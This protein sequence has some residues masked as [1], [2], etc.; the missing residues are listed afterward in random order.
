MTN[1]RKVW[2]TGLRF[3]EA[4]R[5][6]DGAIWLSDLMTEVVWRI[7][8]DTAHATRIA[9]IKDMPCGLGFLPDGQPLVISM[10]SNEVLQIGE[11][12]RL[13]QYALLPQTMAKR[14]NDMAVDPKGRVYVSYRASSSTLR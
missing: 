2:M 7:D 13:S 3:P 10:Q 11:N 1:D 4:P 6:H 12:G 9:Q 5:W 14:L 8:F